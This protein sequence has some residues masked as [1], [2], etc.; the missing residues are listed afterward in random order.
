MSG[1]SRSAWRHSTRRD[2]PRDPVPA[3]HLRSGVSAVFNTLRCLYGLS[4][5]AEVTDPRAVATARLGKMI[6]WTANGPGRVLAMSPPSSRRDLVATVALLRAELRGNRRENEILRDA[7]EPLIHQAPARGRCAFIHARRD[8]FSAKRL[9]NILIT[10]RGNYHAWVRA[11]DK[12]RSRDHDDEEPT[13]WTTEI[14]T[15]HPAYGAERITRELQCQRHH[16]R[17]TDRDP[18]DALA[19][20]HPDHAARAP[21]P[22]QARRRRSRSLGPDPPRVHHADARAEADR[23][24]SA[25]SQRSRAGCTWRLSRTCAERK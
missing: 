17:P 6:S 10:D 9:C 8:R 13:R 7:A 25:A 23:R 20:H 3:E 18:S 22:H 5:A 4:R 15:R 2:S 14:H 21:E 24:T 1:G 12:R 16:G 19:R 11:Q